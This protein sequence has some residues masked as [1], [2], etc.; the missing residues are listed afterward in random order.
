MGEFNIS[1]ALGFFFRDLPAW[2]QERRSQKAWGDHANRAGFAG[3]SPRDAASLAAI[4]QQ[5]EQ[6]RGMEVARGQETAFGQRHGGIGPRGLEAETGQVNAGSARM[7]AKAEQERVRMAQQFLPTQMKH[8]QAQ[9]AGLL[10]GENRAQGEFAQLGGRTPAGVQAQVAEQALPDESALR[11]AQ[12]ENMKFGVQKGQFDLKQLQ[13]S[14]VNPY[15]SGEKSAEAERMSRVANAGANLATAQS[16]DFGGQ[17]NMASLGAMFERIGA[18]ELAKFFGAAPNKNAE[19]GKALTEIVKQFQQGKI[20]K[21]VQ[22]TT[23][24]ITPIPNRPR[25]NNAPR[26]SDGAFISAEDFPSFTGSRVTPVGPMAAPK[27]RDQKTYT[28]EDYVREHPERLPL[29]QQFLQ[30]RGMK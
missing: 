3:L 14:G 22:E 30:S 24:K 26:P 8:V 27:L 15:T 20:G 17:N 11:R 1:D 28:M 13:E 2:K 21:P 5:A 10:G 16:M 19:M 7:N 25:M 12:A 29:L 23:P 6:T 9:T 4:M 18:P